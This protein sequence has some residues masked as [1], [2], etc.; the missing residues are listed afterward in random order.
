MS[1][2]PQKNFIP[3]PLF[4]NDDQQLTAW[5]MLHANPLLKENENWLT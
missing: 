5:C 2:Q 4:S 1:T 3:I